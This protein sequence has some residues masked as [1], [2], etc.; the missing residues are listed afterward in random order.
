MDQSTYM[1]FTKNGED[2]TKIIG[3]VFYQETET[4]ISNFF[5]EE[6]DKPQ[7]INE[8]TFMAKYPSVY[9]DYIREH[10]YEKAFSYFSINKGWIGVTYAYIETRNF[11]GGWFTLY[12]VNTEAK[13]PILELHFN[14][15]A[16]PFL[17]S[18]LLVEL[19][20]V[21]PVP[22]R[23]GKTYYKGND[24]KIY[25]EERAEIRSLAEEA[26]NTANLS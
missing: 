8:V 24:E 15:N 12:A 25:L 10:W 20:Q 26:V 2:F 21:I 22:I 4:V 18:R 16:N 5:D 6:G 23:V 9:I 11:E 19:S 3:P 17:K 14:V 13:A 1:I 7:I